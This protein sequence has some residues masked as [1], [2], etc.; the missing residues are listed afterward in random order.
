MPALSAPDFLRWDEPFWHCL[1]PKKTPGSAIADELWFGA[2]V[3]PTSE[4]VYADPGNGGN[5]GAASWAMIGYRHG[6][7]EGPSGPPP[8]VPPPPRVPVGGLMDYDV[9]ITGA[10]AGGGIAACVLA[11]AG[12]RV[13]LIERGPER[14]YAN[15]GHRDH[16]RNQWLPRYGHNAGPDDIAGNTRVFA[17]PDGGERI[18]AANDRDYQNLADGVG[19]ATSVY[20][21]QAW[22][23]HPDD[24]RTASRYGVPEGSSLVNWPISYDDLAPW[25]E[26]AEWEI[27]VAGAEGNPHEGPRARA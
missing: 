7:P 18:V 8:C 25:Y 12:K 9:I 3:M 16:F 26:R 11:E 4:G 1:T 14:T 17:A 5:V 13:L 15:G 10:G 20:G 6:L 19:G 2:L 21:M 23:F 27:G 24:F 22:R